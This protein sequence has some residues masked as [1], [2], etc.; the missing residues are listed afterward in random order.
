MTKE[1]WPKLILE[2]IEVTGLNST[3]YKRMK[4]LRTIFKCEDI[5]IQKD[6]NGKTNLK[7]FK[8]R[9]DEQISNTVDQNWAEGME[10]KPSLRRYREFKSNRGTYDHIYDNTRGSTLRRSSSGFSQNERIQEQI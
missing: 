8:K 5:S 9:I 6:E 7:S 3:A 4:E 1:K 10:I 2:M